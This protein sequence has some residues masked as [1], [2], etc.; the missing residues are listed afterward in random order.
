MTLV[1][2]SQDIICAIATPS[3]RGGL[4]VIRVSG[5]GA[6]ELVRGLAPFLPNQISSHTVHFGYLQKLPT[7]E[8]VKDRIEERIEER[9]D[10]RIDEVLITFFERGRS[11]SGEE[12]VE[13]SCHGNPLICGEILQEL[14]AAGARM[15][16]PGEFSFRAFMNGRIDLVKAESVH[17]LVASQSAAEK[18]NALKQLTGGISER[19]KQ[20]EQSICRVLAHLEASIDFSTEG[21]EIMSQ[22]ELRQQLQRIKQEVEDLVKGYRQGKI[23]REGF[24]VLFLGRP[25]VGKSSLLNLVLG[26]DRAIVNEQAGTTRDLIEAWT[27]MDGLR[28][29]WLDSAGLRDEA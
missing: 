8:E 19:V 18:R 4:S 29:S 26:E 17:A 25:N 13:I 9:I 15:A 2:Q 21:L 12:T 6:L 5:A 20:I 23:F 3:G 14:S 24:R 22:D 1:D 28:V 16:N 10:D 27:E 11:F 7:V